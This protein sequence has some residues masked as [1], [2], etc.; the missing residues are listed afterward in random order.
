M[1]FFAPAAKPAAKGPLGTQTVRIG[2]LMAQDQK[3][4]VV[5]QSLEYCRDVVIA[6]NLIF[7]K[8]NQ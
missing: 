1:D 4:I 2:F 3:C 6:F 8:V 5:I 7:G